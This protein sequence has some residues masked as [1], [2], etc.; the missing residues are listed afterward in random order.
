M[1]SLAGPIVALSALLLSGCPDGS[2]PPSASQPTKPTPADKKPDP[3]PPPKPAEV[4]PFAHVQVGQVYVF[5]IDY[6]TPMTERREITAKTESEVTA[7]V[8]DELPVSPLGMPPAAPRTK[9]TPRAEPALPRGAVV[10]RSETLTVSGVKFDC[11][12]REEDDSENPGAKVQVW[13]SRKYPG[14]VKKTSGA[15]TLLE[16]IEIRG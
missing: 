9:T 3:P 8:R 13:V 1:R 6:G 10:L 16:L 2:T 14:E 5:R 4:D 12:V 7:S 11:E 15:K